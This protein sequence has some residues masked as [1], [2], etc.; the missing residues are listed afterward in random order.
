MATKRTPA[1]QEAARRNGAKSRGP[2][3]PEG[4]AKSSRNAIVHGCASEILLRGESEPGFCALLDSYQNEYNPQGQTEHDLVE[5]MAYARWAMRRTWSL[6]AAVIDVTLDIQREE[7]D[8][9]F[10]K[11]DS[12][13]R[14]AFAF[15]KSTAE[16]Q[17]LPLLNRY[18]ARHARDYH[19][20]LDKLRVI[21]QERRARTPEE[22]KKQELPNEPEA[23]LTPSASTPDA[24]PTPESCPAAPGP[25]TPPPCSGSTPSLPA[26]PPPPPAPYGPPSTVITGESL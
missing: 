19:R 15:I 10:K 8:Q 3:T 23:G 26:P 7:I 1:Q 24:A 22:T 25:A 12:G 5:E 6:Q 9:K 11:V 20:A 16:S 17:S 14:T 2:V 18:A 13:A 4:K 21:Q